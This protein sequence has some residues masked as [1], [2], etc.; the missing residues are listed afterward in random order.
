MFSGQR[1]LTL[2]IS[3]WPLGGQ[4]SEL[5]QPEI[6]TTSRKFA[7]HHVMERSIEPFK[8][9]LTRPGLPGMVKQ[10]LELLEKGDPS[11]NRSLVLVDSFMGDE[12]ATAVV[13]ALRHNSSVKSLDLRGCNIR[14]EGASALA[15]LLEHNMNLTSVG[16]E[17]NSVGMLESG[18]QS[19]S[20][21]CARHSGLF[22]SPT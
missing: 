22:G 6:R 11:E 2:L 3:P 18:I 8:S 19:I 20:K 21:V 16:L 1:L 10:K 9:H 4:R 5:A 17:W 12:G 14:S 7:P 13:D 15:G